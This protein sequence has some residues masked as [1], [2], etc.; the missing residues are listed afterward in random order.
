MTGLVQRIGDGVGTNEQ[1]H[2][3]DGD[4]TVDDDSSTHSFYPPLP[5]QPAP[6][7]VPPPRSPNSQSPK[8][9]ACSRKLPTADLPARQE[10]PEASS[11]DGKGGS[12]AAAPDRETQQCEL[13]PPPS[14]QVAPPSTDFSSCRP[15]MLDGHSFVPAA[16]LLALFEQRGIG[17][18]LSR[19][20]HGRRRVSTGMNVFAIL[21]RLKGV[22]V[23]VW[24]WGWVAVSDCGVGWLLDAGLGGAPMIIDPM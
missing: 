24:C 19:R 13:S 16:D 15:G 2:T 17:K 23:L 7:P 12:E 22:L 1:E 4:G 8:R 20:A 21:D 18:T 9:R 10:A 5:P 11:R 3:C 14:H 6:L